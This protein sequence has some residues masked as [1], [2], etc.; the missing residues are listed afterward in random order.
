A[1][2]PLPSFPFDLGYDLRIGTIASEAAKIIFDL[3]E[4]NYYGTSKP[5]LQFGQLYSFIRDKAVTAPAYSWDEDSRLLAC[6]ALSR[7]IHPTSVS[8]RYAGRIRYDSDSCISDISPAYIKGV[9]I[10]TFLDGTPK[11]DWLTEADA[12]RLRGLLPTLY[13]S[14]VP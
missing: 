3:G 11:R 6:V 9:G 8:L 2:D 13:S 4:P 12:V 14:A 10:D 7:I 1:S 5:V